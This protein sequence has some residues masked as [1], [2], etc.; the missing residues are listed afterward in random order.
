MK[1]AT[2]IEIG[3]GVFAIASAVAAAAWHEHDN[4]EIVS[5]EL[6]DLLLQRLYDIRGEQDSMGLIE[7]KLP[8][9]WG[10]QYGFLGFDDVCQMANIAGHS[11]YIAR[12]IED[13]K[14]SLP[15]VTLQTIRVNVHGDSKTLTSLYPTWMDL[16]S[17]ENFERARKY[18]GDTLILL[19]IDV[20]DEKNAGIGS[21]V[22][23]VVFYCSPPE[24]EHVRSTTPI[25]GKSVDQINLS[26]SKT[27]T[28]S[29]RF[30]AR[31][32]AVPMMIKEGYKSPVANE[33]HGADIVF[34]GYDRDANHNWPTPKPENLTLHSM[35]PAQQKLSYAAHQLQTLLPRIAHIPTY[36]FLHAQ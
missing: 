23:N 17:R 8:E 18:G 2:K 21:R 4:R 9:E 10:R 30:H 31:G 13:G 16:V 29:M 5:A 14:L 1:T 28:S 32:G 33:R 6:P 25:D 24:I 7:E 20:F 19:Q 36:S 22:R 35:G 15:K 12:T 11:I 3:T 26:D 34:M 27:Y